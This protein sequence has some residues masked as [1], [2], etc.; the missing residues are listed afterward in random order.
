MRLFMDDCLLYRGRFTFAK[1]TLSSSKTYSNW[2]YGQDSGGWSSTLGNDI[3]WAYAA[4]HPTYTPWKTTSWSKSHQSPTS[5]FISLGICLEHEHHHQK[6]NLLP[7]PT[8]KNVRSCPEEC[9]RTALYLVLV[10]S[11]LEYSAVV[12]DPYQQRNINKLEDVQ[13]HTAPFVKQDYRSRQPGSITKM[14]KDL[15]LP[16]VQDRWR[17]K[18]LS[19]STKLLKVSS[20]PFQQN[21]FWHMCRTRGRSRPPADLTSPPATSSGGS[22]ETTATASLWVVQKQIP[23]ETAF[24]SELFLTGT[25]SQTKWCLQSRWRK[26]D[27]SSQPNVKCSP[28]FSVNIYARTWP[29]LT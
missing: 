21:L 27:P 5:E 2:R 29:K 6:S 1:T 4:S 8:E 14:L 18:R 11:V 19:C 15:N 3:S 25:T 24:S 17:E 16:S 7:Q 10:R 9:R 20:Q 23:T 13:R 26:F 22:P 28:C 12:W